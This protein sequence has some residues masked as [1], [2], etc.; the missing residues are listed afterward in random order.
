MSQSQPGALKAMPAARSAILDRIKARGD[1]TLQELADELGHTRE[2][3]RQQVSIL[4][5]QGWLVRESLPSEGRGRPEYR[6]TLSEAGDHL[7]PKHY[8][9][10]SLALVDTMAEELGEQ[11]LERLLAALT[12]RQVE[13]WRDRLAGQPLAERLKRLK[14]IYYEDDPWTD[15]NQDERGWVLVERNC[16]FL[17]LAQRRPKLCSVT[18]STLSRLL[19]VEVKREARFQDGDRRCVFRVLAD[20]PLPDG[21]RFAFEDEPEPAGQGGAA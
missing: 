9:R 2:A 7:F 6:Y 10:M 4:L 3:V 8:D 15:V 1:A 20:R 17:N 19:G 14:G 18:V 12:D 5:D 13:E 21:F 16:P 11:G